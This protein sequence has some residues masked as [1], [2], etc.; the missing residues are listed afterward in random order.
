MVASISAIWIYNTTKAII[1]GDKAETV[2]RLEHTLIGQRQ[3]L[4][5]GIEQI[6]QTYVSIANGNLNARVPLAQDHKL[7]PIAQALNSLLIRLQRASL[8]ER[9]LHR[10]Q[11]AVTI[12]VKIIQ[13]SSQERQKAHIPFTQTA[14][15]PLIAA[16]QGKTFA[17]TRPLLQQ[18]NSQSAR[19]INTHGAYDP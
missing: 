5:S 12:T 3:E 10:A 19:S 6:L 14:I 17:F 13:K 8:S 11:H 16:I 18:K 4:E 1:S 9:E 7:W 15:D 2:A